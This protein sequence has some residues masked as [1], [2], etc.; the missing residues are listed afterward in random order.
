MLE[1]LLNSSLIR[2]A[3]HIAKSDTQDIFLV[4]GALRDLYLTGSIPKDLDFLVTNNVKSLVHVFSHSYHG[5]FFCLDRKRECYRVFITHHDKYYTI[6]FSPI[7]NGDIYNDLLSRD[8][9][10]NSIALTLSDIFEKREL[11]FIDPTGG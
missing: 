9:S 8:F 4:G 2:T 3:Y 5:S 1:Q 6:D 7:L 11:N 10:I